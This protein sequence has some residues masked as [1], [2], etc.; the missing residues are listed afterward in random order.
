[1]EIRIEHTTDY[2]WDLLFWQ[3]LTVNWLTAI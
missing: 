2:P 1:M 3:I